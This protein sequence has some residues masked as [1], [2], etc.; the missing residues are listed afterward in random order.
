M[1]NFNENPYET[2]W[3]PTATKTQKVAEIKNNQKTLIIFPGENRDEFYEIEGHSNFASQEEV[4]EKWV[5]WYLY[6]HPEMAEKFLFSNNGAH[7]ERCIILTH[8]VCVKKI[9]KNDIHYIH[10][11]YKAIMP[12]DLE[13]N[14]RKKSI[15]AESNP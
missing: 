2:M 10:E 14:D 11:T 3:F 5:W 9:S 6:W 1:T 4:D 8:P 7:P 12:N 13:P 15:P